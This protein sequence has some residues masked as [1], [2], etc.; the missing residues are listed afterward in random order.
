MKFFIGKETFFH[1][2]TVNPTIQPNETFLVLLL[3]A[4]KCANFEHFSKKKPPVSYIKGLFHLQLSFFLCGNTML[5]WMYYK[6]YLKC[7]HSIPLKVFAF[8]G[9]WRDKYKYI[10]FSVFWEKLVS[11]VKRNVKEMRTQMYACIK[12][13]RLIGSH[14]IHAN[15]NVN[16]YTYS[17]VFLSN[18]VSSW[19]SPFAYSADVFRM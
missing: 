4:H 14:T 10:D 11:N 15:E 7:V 9:S 19:K 2:L 5:C 17:Q 3:E 12:F 13:I 8:S 18:K 1:P 6:L 16:C